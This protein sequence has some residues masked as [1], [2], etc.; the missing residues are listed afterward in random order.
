MYCPKCCSKTRVIGTV[1]GQTNE[2]F[3]KCTVCGHSFQTVEAIKYDEY[4]KEY[5]ESS[6]ENSLH[7]NRIKK[8][9]NL[10][11]AS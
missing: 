2:R 9:G 4:W 11:T 3:R 8:Y 6:I 5:K 7:F 10:F 1:A